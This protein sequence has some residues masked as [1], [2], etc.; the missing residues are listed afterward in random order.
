MLLLSG[1]CL[2]LIPI[3]PSVTP[4]A[5]PRDSNLQVTTES[6]AEARSLLPFPPEI[7]GQIRGLP[8]LKTATRSNQQDKTVKNRSTRAMKA[9]ARVRE[10]HKLRAPFVVRNK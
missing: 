2:F 5:N 4:K 10:Q 1:S 7:T 6:R 3:S 8:A 9:R